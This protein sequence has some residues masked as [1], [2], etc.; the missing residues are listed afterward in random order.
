MYQ[1]YFFV[2]CHF[3]LCSLF[4]HMHKIFQCSAY[5]VAPFLMPVLIIP[6]KVFLVL[7][8]TMYTKHV[9]VSRQI[10]LNTH[11]FGNKRLLL[12]LLPEKLD[13]LIFAVIPSPPI[14]S[15]FCESYQHTLLL[16]NFRNL[17]LYLYLYTFDSTLNK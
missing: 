13:S 12:Y 16:E 7:P 2:L 11:W 17:L 4:K 6:I 8:G 15:W 5:I 10:P 1:S 3:L 14:Y 9:F